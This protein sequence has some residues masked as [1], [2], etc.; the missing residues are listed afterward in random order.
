MG[1]SAFTARECDYFRAACNFTAQERAVFDLRVR[2]CSV[3]EIAMALHVSAS[4][5]DRRVRAVKRKIERVL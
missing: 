3:V 2:G 5:V 4:T 1:L